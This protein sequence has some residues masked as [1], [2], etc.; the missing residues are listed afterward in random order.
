M[1][2][3]LKIYLSFFNSAIRELGP[4]IQTLSKSQTLSFFSSYL[5]LS[6]AGMTPRQKS[7]LSR[8]LAD[9]S[10]H[11]I[12]HSSDPGFVLTR[13]KTAFLTPLNCEYFFFK[14]I[15][16]IYSIR[17]Q[18][19][20]NA[21][22]VELTAHSPQLAGDRIVALF[23]EN[24]H[25]TFRIE[26]KNMSVYYFINKFIKRH[27]TVTRPLYQ[28]KIKGKVF[29]ALEN[30]TNDDLTL[31]A[32]TWTSLH[33]YFHTNGALPL[34]ECLRYKS[35]REAGAVEELR[36]DLNVLSALPKIGSIPEH[37]RFGIRQFILAERLLYYASSQ[38]PNIDYDAIS[39]QIL[40]N[41]LHK[42]GALTMREET[43]TLN[44]NVWEEIEVLKLELNALEMEAAKV[45]PGESVKLFTAYARS[46][47]SFDS[48]RNTYTWIFP[49]T[50]Y[51]NHLKTLLKTLTVNVAR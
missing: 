49:Y 11:N 20:S 23:P 30:A 28:A 38:D 43:L 8:A 44:E 17:K 21:K 13:M 42:Q 29:S 37:L 1:D 14:N 16:D 40:F 34:P 47:G 4:R 5:A 48:S 12:F 19:P 51:H 33:E 35:T 18:F 2:K 41:H 9:N 7:V 25:P 50:E 3:D 24:W 32:T 22:P 36:V 15:E 31:F 10:S 26:M 46:H 45:S 6:R 39:S 27:L